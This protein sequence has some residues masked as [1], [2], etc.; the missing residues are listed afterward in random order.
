[1]VQVAVELEHVVL[2]MGVVQRVQLEQQTLVVEVERL[3]VMLLLELD[4][5]VLELLLLD[6][7]FNN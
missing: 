4:L 1:V 3:I 6:T 7:N 5:V 2:Q